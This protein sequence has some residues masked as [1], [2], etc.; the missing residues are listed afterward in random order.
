MAEEITLGD[1]WGVSEEI[2]L[3]PIDT[4]K[5]PPTLDPASA[6]IQMPRAQQEQQG[7]N[8]ESDR[9]RQIEAAVVKPPPPV[10]FQSLRTGPDIEI[11]YEPNQALPV[12]MSDALLRGLSPF[13]LQVEPPFI[14]GDDGG[15][16]NRPINSVNIDGYT[17]AQQRVTR[18]SASRTSLAQSGILS[19][20]TNA[21]G[22][23]EYVTKDAS[24]KTKNRGPDSNFVDDDGE[25]GSKLGQPAI[26]DLYAATDIAWQLSAMLNTPP[27]VLLINPNNL[28]MARNKVQQYQDRTRFGYILHA[29]G[30]EQPRLSITAKC[31]AFVSGGRG[32][33]FASKRDSAAWQNLMNAFHFFKNNG[34]IHDTV[35]RSFAHHHIGSLSIHYDGW[36]YYGSMES[37]SYSYEDSTNMLGGVEFSMEFVVSLE[38][39]TT[40]S[41]LAVQPMRSPTP[42]PSDPR[43]QGL[44]NRAQN[45]PGEFSVGLSKSGEP[46][47]FEQGR[48]V[49]IGD[50][51]LSTPP[52]EGLQVYNEDYKA[53]T[54]APPE[55]GR[56]TG[57]TDQPTGRNGFQASLPAIEPGSRPITQTA[58]ERSQPFTGR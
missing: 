48:Q 44:E 16:L 22:V 56:Q 8:Y 17:N 23:E 1:D 54:P 42:S 35:G 53:A 3:E 40:A 55:L 31:G 46:Q 20:S 51:V 33:Q 49:T 21:Q 15:F 19:I 11:E 30:E 2:T 27:L 37:F 13:M 43:Y 24:S 12:E 58:P 6:R 36:I 29:W 4:T 5:S 18:Y 25:N 9:A 26:A 50:M 41:T 14:F 28:A 38:V 52:E 32:V 7:I 47:L 39:D 34:Y 45:R 57:V 10:A